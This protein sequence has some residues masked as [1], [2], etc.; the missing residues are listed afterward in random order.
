MVAVNMTEKQF[1]AEMRRWANQH[2]PEIGKFVHQK[3]T[4]FVYEGIVQKTP[5]L[6]GRARN[7]WFPTVGAP[8]QTTTKQV[9]SVSITG[10]PMTGE[11]KTRIGAVT[12]KL[13]ALP[14]GQSSAYI[15]NNLDYIG[16]LEDGYS[17]KAPPNA[18]VQR[19]IINT[20]DE[21]KVTISPKIGA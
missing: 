5:V 2:V 11:E 7:N 10:A 4:D 12:Q 18:M 21:L 6:T 19:T 17:P 20:L 16:R 8:T 3:V 9:A 14:L 15:T 1:N 13:D